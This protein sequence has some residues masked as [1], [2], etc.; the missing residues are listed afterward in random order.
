MLVPRIEGRRQLVSGNFSNL[1][2]VSLYPMNKMIRAVLALVSIALCSALF[3]GSRTWNIGSADD[4]RNIY[5]EMYYPG[6]YTFELI[7]N[8]TSQTVAYMTTL[9]SFSYSTPDTCY[10]DY[11][12]GSSGTPYLV[13]SWGSWD[14]AGRPSGDYSVRVSDSSQPDWSYEL[15]NV[16]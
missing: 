8:T 10:D 5:I 2:I 9:A 6:D 7:N 14:L 1:M 13:N 11:Y 3:A 15:S 16:F 12:Y 4:A